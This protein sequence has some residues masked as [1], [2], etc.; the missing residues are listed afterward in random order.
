MT[1]F[2]IYKFLIFLFF[3]SATLVKKGINFK[4]SISLLEVSVLNSETNFHL[5]LPPLLVSH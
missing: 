2:L 5:L 4:F 1:F 3:E